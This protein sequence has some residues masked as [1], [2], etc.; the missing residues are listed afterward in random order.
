MFVEAM[1]GTYRDTAELV[2]LCD[3][4]QR[5]M[6]WYNR[7]LETTAGLAPRPTWGS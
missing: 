2:G 5:R 1:A 3:L 6:N 7:R 4:S